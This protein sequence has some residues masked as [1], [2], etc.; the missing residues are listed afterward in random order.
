M[1]KF[2]CNYNNLTEKYELSLS[3]NN[4]F[5]NKSSIQAEKTLLPQI[6]NDLQTLYENIVLIKENEKD[7][8]KLNILDE[9]ELMIS[10]LYYSLF[11]SPLELTNRKLIEQEKT[12]Q[13]C[14]ALAN[15]LEKNI[16]IPE[17]NRSISLIKNNLILLTK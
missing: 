17:Y 7:E 11:A 2:F 9:T 10:N 6:K 14:L 3:K 13:N 4:I 12:L 8:N 5:L 16:N 1:H 15:Q